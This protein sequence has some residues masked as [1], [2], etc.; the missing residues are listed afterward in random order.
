MLTSAFQVVKVH[1]QNQKYEGGTSELK[2]F[3]EVLVCV[4]NHSTE[5]FLAFCLAS[6]YFS[7]TQ[8][9]LTENLKMQLHS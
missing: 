1:I 9:I 3:S 6:H 7:L 5:N 4:I 8:Y 2:L